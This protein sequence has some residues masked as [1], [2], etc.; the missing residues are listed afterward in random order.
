MPGVICINGCF[1]PSGEAPPIFADQ[2]LLYGFG[3]F[4]TVLVREGKPL[5]MDAHLERLLAGCTALN[6]ALP[7][8]PEE[9]DCLA[10]ETVRRNGLRDCALRLTLTAGQSPGETPGTLLISTRPLPYRPEDYR[11]GFAAGWVPF[12]RNER[13]P[14]VKLKTLNYLENLL[15]RREARRKGWD[16]AIFLNTA[17]LV[18]EGTASNVFIVREG[19]VITPAADQG[20]LPGIMRRA[21][22]EACC[23]VGLT[24]EE[25]PVLPQELEGAEECFLTNSLMV[26]MPLVKI[27]GRP[28]GEGQ[29]GPITLRLKE[30]VLRELAASCGAPEGA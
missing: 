27:N 9:I 5:L 14:L 23:R 12:P 19:K 28:V 13:S 26:V 18:A 22:L 4:E 20:L 1:L 11:K 24:A 7:C 6:L 25:R 8:S 29:P 16:E 21:V 3:L 30:A 15:A 10:Q 17:G 2:G